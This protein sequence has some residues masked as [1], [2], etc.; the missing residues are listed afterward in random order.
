MDKQVQEL[1]RAL[2]CS[3]E[4]AKDII[5]SDRRIDKG[6]KLFQLTAEQ[7]KASKQARSVSRGPTAYKFPK[8]ERKPNQPKRNLIEFLSDSLQAYGV[9]ELEVTN[10]ERQLDFKVEGVRYRVILSAPRK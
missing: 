3:E 7:E 5:E 10:I 8:R 1:M 6:E 2:D 9:E 4:E